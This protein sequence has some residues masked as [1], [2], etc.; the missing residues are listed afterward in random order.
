MRRQ[1]EDGNEKALHCFNVDKLFHGAEQSL[2][3]AFRVQRSITKTAEERKRFFTLIK[4]H[5]SQAEL[6]IFVVLRREC[7]RRKFSAETEN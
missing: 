7:L 6:C 3:F 1:N 4:E 5:Q 2:V